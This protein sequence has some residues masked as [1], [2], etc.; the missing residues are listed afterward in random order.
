MQFPHFYNMY[1]SPKVQYTDLGWTTE[2]QIL[3]PVQRQQLASCEVTFCTLGETDMGAGEVKI[4][5]LVFNFV[6][7]LSCELFVDAVS[8]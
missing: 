7:N 6:T 1:G 8:I 2:G 3:A 4:L 5:Y